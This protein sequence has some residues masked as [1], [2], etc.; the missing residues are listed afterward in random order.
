MNSDPSLR[1]LAQI[2]VQK[3]VSFLAVV[4]VMLTLLSVASQIVLFFVNNGKTALRINRVIDVNCEGNLPTWF[5]SALLLLT[6]LLL[7]ACAQTERRRGSGYVRYWTILAGIFVF[8]SA[9]ET[10]Q[11]HD[12]SIKPLRRAL[13]ADGIFYFTWVIPGILFVAAVGLWSLRFLASLDRRTRNRFLLAGSVYISGSLIMEMVDGVW[14]S[15][16]GMNF[17]YFL[18]T[19]LEELLEMTGVLVFMHAILR[20]LEKARRPVKTPVES[21]PVSQS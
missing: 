17:F 10:A 6:A 3:V 1:V 15:R 5:S 7:I 21:V 20:F 8:L 9:D 18:L 13:G 14:A 4:M 11:F 2:P 12:K 16:H 19:D